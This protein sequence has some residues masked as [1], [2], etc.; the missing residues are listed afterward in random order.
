MI[1]QPLLD[2]H[3]KLDKT[4]QVI[5]VNF[6]LGQNGLITYVQVHVKFKSTVNLSA[7]QN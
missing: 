2:W 5:Q 3:L 7:R 6:A 1:K 4:T